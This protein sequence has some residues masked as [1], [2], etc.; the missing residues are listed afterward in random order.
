MKTY[1]YAQ[2]ASKGVLDFKLIKDAD[3]TLYLWVYNEERQV[4]TPII[5]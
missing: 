1:T 2:A 5:N 3:P 4:F